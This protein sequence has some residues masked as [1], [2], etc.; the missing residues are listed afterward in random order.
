MNVIPRYYAGFVLIGCLLLLAGKCPPDSNTG[1]NSNTGPDATPP[2]FVQVMV[3]LE[4]PGDPNSRGDFDITNADVNKTGIPSDLVLHIQATAGDSE[5]GITKVELETR[6]VFDKAQNKDVMS[7]LTWS[8]SSGH[9]GGVLVPVLQAGTMPFTLAA[10]PSPAPKLWQVDAT[11]NPITSTNCTI[12]AANGV[13]PVG[14]D[15]FIRL[16]ATNGAGQTA[17]SKTFIFSY[18]DVGS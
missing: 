3:K 4:K 10:P 5:S 2:G 15:G 16:K 9:H 14:I 6:Q 13:G 17:V 11:A 7:N 8:C 12:D 1:T 18:A